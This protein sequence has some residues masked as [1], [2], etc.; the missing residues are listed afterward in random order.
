MSYSLFE[1]PLF[2]GL[3]GDEEIA[4]HF[5][6][7]A[8]L[9][10]ILVF[11]AALAKAEARHGVIPE[12][13]AAL[14][15]ETC[16]EFSP[17]TSALRSAA[18][19]DGVVVPELVRQL[20]KAVGDDAAPYVHFGATSQD[21]VDTSL[22]LRLKAVFHL[23]AARLSAIIDVLNSLEKDFGGNRLMGYTR[24]QPAIP[25]R[26]HDRLRAWR[27]P[28]TTYLDRLGRTDKEFLTVQ[29]GGAA[30]TLDKLGERAEAVRATL[31]QELGLADAPQWH[32]QRSR[33]AEIAHRLAS[34]TGSLGKFGQ[35]VALLAE[36]GGEIELAG[37]GGSSAMPH[38][39]NPIA[40]E[41]LVALARFNAAQI[42]GMH[43][44]LI[45]EQERSGA[46]WTLEWLIL[47]PMIG[48]TAAALRLAGELALSVRRLGQP[49]T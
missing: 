4:A 41:M 21:A 24:M 37:G 14:I 20:R 32:S 27:D 22:M 3:M 25:I 10:A 17:H 29:L 12:Q 34:I 45:H 8:D 23:F 39:Q 15:G 48:A 38:K 6:A 31:A 26:V 28:L 40:A 16:A 2:S 30:G 43:Q 9:R 19:R 42:S 44:A 47:P 11:E 7:Q 18:A 46:A 1:H 49:P 35:D 5:S 36:T 13:A 33:T